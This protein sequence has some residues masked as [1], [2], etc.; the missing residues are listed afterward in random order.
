MM[1]VHRN[2][3]YFIL[4]LIL[5]AFVGSPSLAQTH[6]FPAPLCSSVLNDSV[7]ESWLE[8]RVQMD[9][10][11]VGENSGAYADPVT[12][13]VWRVKYFTRN[14][15][16]QYKLEP[17]G[18]VL[19]DFTGKKVE[20]EFDA[21]SLHFDSSLIVINSNREILVLPFEERGRFHHSSLS[22]GQNVIFAGTATFA[23]GKIRSLSDM[24]GHYKPDALQFLIALRTLFKVGVDMTQLRIEGHLARDVFGTASMSQS[25]VRQ[26]LGLL[27][28]TREISQDEVQA[29]L[30]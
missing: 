10:A 15:L 9:K 3:P 26:K 18:D 27:F 20:S 29:L 30:K 22:S 17:K 8:R 5:S 19:V 2:L 14:E 13:A 7:T 25:E 4:V 12:R 1:N 16:L 28:E 23:N 21:D 11:Y 24:S 6:V